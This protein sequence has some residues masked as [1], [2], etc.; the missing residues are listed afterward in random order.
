MSI[1]RYLEAVARIPPGETRTFG[2]LAAMAGRP[3]AARA[4]GRAVAGC[5]VGAGVPWHRVVAADGSLSPQP[6]RAVEQLR[7]LRR[8]GARPGPG[9]SVRDWALRVGARWVGR[10][11]GRTLEIAATCGEAAPLRV[12]PFRDE[13]AARCRGFSPA[14]ER[15]SR[16][17]PLPRRRSRTR[18]ARTIRE[19]IASVDWVRA[20][21]SLARR[22]HVRLPRLLAAAEC[23]DLIAC[24]EREELFE[25]TIEMGPRGYGTGDYR[26]FRD[27]PPPPVGAVRHLLYARLRR[28][29]DAWRRPRPAEARYPPMLREFHEACRSAGQARGSTIL[30]RYPAGGINHPHRDLYGPVWFPFQALVVLSRRGTD[31]TGGRLV[32]MEEMPGGAERERRVAVDRGDLV[33]FASRERREVRGSARRAVP[34]RHGMTMVR[35]GERFALGIVF[36]LAK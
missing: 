17:A 1:G 33:I 36:H 28:T 5:P 26:Y 3:G 8:E 18:P 9:E 7:R 22:G 15:P 29:A 21:G 25:R 12:E 4:A 34:M 16:F 10:L 14:G 30:L 32:L 31:F 20:T 19:R 11:P 27:P 6:D 13:A 35:R 23:E 24:W 2:E